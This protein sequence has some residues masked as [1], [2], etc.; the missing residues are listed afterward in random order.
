MS[1]M[2]EYLMAIITGENE[3]LPEPRSGFEREF[4]EAAKKGL[5]GASSWNELTDRPFGETTVTGDTLTWDGNTEGLEVANGI[6]YRVSDIFP[7]LSDLQNGVSIAFNGSSENETATVQDM[8]EMFGVESYMLLDSNEQSAV[9][10]ISQT[11]TENG[12]TIKKGIYF[13]NDGSTYVTTLTINGYNGFETTETVPLPN[14]YLDIIETVGGDTLTWDGD[15]DGLVSFET[16]YRIS[17][18]YPPF[19]VAQ[20]NTT[21]TLNDPTGMVEITSVAMVDGIETLGIESYIVRINDEMP[22]IVAVAQDS[23]LDEF[24]T[25]AKGIYFV[26]Q[27]GIYVNSLTIN[28]Y[29]GFTKEQVKQEYLP[30]GG[31]EFVVTVA[32]SGET[33]TVDKTFDEISNA[34]ANGKTVIAVL[35]LDG[36]NFVCNL[37]LFAETGFAFAN[38][39]T[40]NGNMPMITEVMIT[41]ENAITVTTTNLTKA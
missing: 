20:G 38:V 13:A 30:S 15:T 37:S 5:G 19:E 27:D 25:L 24:T 33:Y 1:R 11:R 23:A 22:V 14:K 7:S 31:G 4:Y 40:N 28:G 39:Y 32:Q 36:M 2:D 17:S 6:F 12:V 21:F 9:M 18:E 8:T 26:S 34:R 16:F 29:T 10:A 3:D 35:S 41:N